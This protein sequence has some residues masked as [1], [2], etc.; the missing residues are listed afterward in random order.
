MNVAY[1]I[2]QYPAPSHSFI[3]REVVAL[4]AAGI[5]VHVFSIRRFKGSLVSSEDQRENRT[6]RV[7]L[8]RGRSW[9]VG[10]AIAALFASPRRMLRAIW[11][12]VRM[13]WRSDP[14][15]TRHLAYVAEAS[16]LVRW[17]GK[18]QIDHLHAHFGTNPAAVAM[19]CQVLGGPTWSFTAHGPEE[20]ELGDAIALRPKIAAARFVVG[21]SNFGITQLQNWCDA[22]DWPKLK[23]VRCGL[24]EAFFESPPTDVPDVNKIV[25]VG[26]LCEAKMQHVLI[27]AIA[28]LVQRN[29]SVDLTLIGGGPTRDALERQ[30]ETL[31]LQ[32]QVHFA[33]WCSEEQVRREITAS[34]VKVLPSRAE[35]LPVAIMEAYALGRPVV[36][37][38]VAGIPE[39]IENGKSG[40]LVPPG[41]PEALADAIEAAMAAP[42]STLNTMAEIGRQRVIDLH[43]ARKNACVLAQLF[44]GQTDFIAAT[45]AAGRTH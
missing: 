28:Q 15:V 1:L 42:V 43:D 40:W 29:V 34:R 36:S 35:G 2:N 32:S 13:G 37:T 31:G 41:Q 24:D 18:F 21:I 10:N 11:M 23:L 27:D 38:T 30:V 16:A 19:L 44:A 4:R 33:G 39:L 5:N 17:L 8:E 12:A 22:K 6:T 25:C 7:I 3:R 45:H 26:R 14:G 9:L 20:F